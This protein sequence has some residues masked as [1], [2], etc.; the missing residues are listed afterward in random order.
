[1]VLSTA[2]TIMDVANTGMV[3]ASSAGV[4]VSAVTIEGDTST[5]NTAYNTANGYVA[6]WTGIQPGADGDFSIHYRAVA[7]EAYGPSVYMLA[8]EP[9]TTPTIQV[10]GA[11]T[12]FNSQAGVAST[13]QTTR[14]PASGSR[15]ASALMRRPCLNCQPTEA[16]I[17]PA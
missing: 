16:A 8:E 1:V 12:G 10:S 5:F 11:L 2:F 15:M 4:A 7:N 13:A 14:F 17:P 3:N 9:N 6:R